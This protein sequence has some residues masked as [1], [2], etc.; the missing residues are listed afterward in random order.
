MEVSASPETGWRTAGTPIPKV[1]AAAIVTGAQRYPT[2]LSRPGMLRGRVLRPPAFGATLRSVDAADAQAMPDVSVVHEDDFVG[3]VA[4][5]T[6][7]ARR[8][9][10]A[11]RAEWDRAPQ[12]SEDELIDAP[13]C[14]TGGAFR[15]AGV[16]RS[17]PPRGGRRGRGAR[18]GRRSPRPD[19]HDRIHRARAARDASRAG[20]VGRRPPHRVDRHAAAVRRAGGARGGAGRAGGA[21][22]RDRARH[23]RRLR[24]QA[25]R[26]G[27]DRGGPSVTRERPAR[28]RD[29]DASGGVHLGVRPPGRRDRRPLRCDERR[30]PHRLGVHEHQLRRRGDP[31]SVRDPQPADRVPPRRLPVAAGLLPRAGRDGEPLRPG[32]APGRAGAPGRRRSVGAPSAASPRRPARGRVPGGGRAGGPRPDAARP[33]ARDRH[34]GRR[35]EGRAGRHVP[36]RSASMRTAGWRSSGS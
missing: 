9:I 16:G 10:D 1:T 6:T 34:R 22:A 27:R 32:V 26:R 11:I 4:P 2:D 33:R 25:H 20:G 21:G 24:R 13:A 3:V 35:R 18:G 8:G 14:D 31:V 29:L 19:V 12:P 28:E 15:I 23:G 36:S 17:V 7:T 5:D 30:R